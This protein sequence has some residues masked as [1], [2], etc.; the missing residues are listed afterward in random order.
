MELMQ[1]LDSSLIRV[2][3][4]QLRISFLGHPVMH[5]RLANKRQTAVRNE[6]AV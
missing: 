1:A 6:A 2:A 3:I 4:D 5:W